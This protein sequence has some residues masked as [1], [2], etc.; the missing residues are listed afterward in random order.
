MMNYRRLNK[1]DKSLWNDYVE[2]QPHSTPYHRFEWMESIEAAYGH[3]AIA[4]IGTDEQGVIQQALP[5]VQMKTPLKA[6]SLCSLP[7]CDVGGVLNS[8]P[9]LTTEGLLAFIETQFAGMTTE[10]IE[11]RQRGEALSDDALEAAKAD[12]I[13]VSMLLGLPESSE[14]LLKSFKPK[15]RSQIKKAEKNGLTFKTAHGAE[16]IDEF[17]EVISKNMRNLGSPVHSKA[18]YQAIMQN[19]GKNAVT[20]VVYT[21]GVPAAAGIVLTNQHKACIPWA[22]SLRE[23]NRLAPNMM[24]YWSLLAHCA[25]NNITE[26]DF[27]RSTLNEGTYRFKKQWLAE[28]VHLTWQSLAQLREGVVDTATARGGKT[29]DV[30]EKVWQKLPLGVTVAIGPVV[31]KHISL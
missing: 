9:E 24:L 25:D 13:K 5:L 22:S 18:F 29:R 17:Y 23:Y 31:R 20:S 10:R 16:L 12:N 27:G 26:F 1:A 4:V 15:L 2:A 3:N 7:F 14:A 30:I 28:P 21:E 6:P 19:Y 11:I 8:D